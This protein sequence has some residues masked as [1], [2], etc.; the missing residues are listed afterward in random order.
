M[1]REVKFSFEGGG[2][3]GSRPP[4]SEFSESAP[5]KVTAMVTVRMQEGQL[6]TSVSS[7]DRNV[8]G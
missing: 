8:R 7:D 4:I 2:G 1:S 5:G 3:G 6:V